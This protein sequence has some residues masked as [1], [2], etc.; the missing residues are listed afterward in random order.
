MVRFKIFYVV[1]SIIYYLVKI[2][3]NLRSLDVIVMFVLGLIFHIS[4]IYRW[5][6]SLYKII[7]LDG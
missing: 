1:R 6:N 4:D 7:N 5:N 3:D 2:V